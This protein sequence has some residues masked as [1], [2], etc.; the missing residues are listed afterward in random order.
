MPEGPVEQLEE[1][2]RDACIRLLGT[3]GIG[4]V[5]IVVDGFPT[6]L[7]VNYRV[8][9]TGDGLQLVIRTRLGSP[10]DRSARAGFEVDG[11]DPAHRQGWS[12]LLRGE[13]VHLAAEDVAAFG[14]DID[15][16]PWVGERDSWLVLRAF[17]VSGR[18]LHPRTVEWQVT[19]R[20]YL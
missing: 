16:A 18:L 13:L 9:R 4:R 11:V 14:P 3:S 6:V 19:V 7:P 12:V 10:L 20:A 8:W 15:P 1:L 5:A 17:D 2:D